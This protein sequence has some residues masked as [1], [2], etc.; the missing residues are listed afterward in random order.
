MSSF[1]IW[2]DVSHEDQE[3]KKAEFLAVAVVGDRILYQGANQ[4]DQTWYQVIEKDGKKE[5]QWTYV[6]Y[7]YDD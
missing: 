7:N 3:K 4:M 6:P 5:L 2:T 1:M